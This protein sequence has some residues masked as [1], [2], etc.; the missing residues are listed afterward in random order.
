MACLWLGRYFVAGVVEVRD[1]GVLVALALAGVSERLWVVAVAEVLPC[2]GPVGWTWELV[3]GLPFWVALAGAIRVHAVVLLLALELDRPWAEDGAGGMVVLRPLHAVSF[4]AL[5]RHAVCHLLR[6]AS[7]AFYL[8]HRLVFRVVDLVSDA[9]HGGVDRFGVVLG[10]RLACPCDR[11]I[12]DQE[13]VCGP[14]LDGPELRPF[15]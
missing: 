12:F 15:L 4:L 10:T 7:L 9:P 6:F 1:G 8:D 3:V 11:L 14:A 13:S 5:G 2:V